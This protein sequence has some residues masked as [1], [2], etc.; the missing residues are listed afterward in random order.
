[1]MRSSGAGGPASLP[2]LA[3]LAGRGAGGGRDDAACL[4]LDGSS[5]AVSASPPP[6][7]LLRECTPCAPWQAIPTRPRAS[8]S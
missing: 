6:H 8:V 3:L 7:D 5:G 1:M 4:R 2:P